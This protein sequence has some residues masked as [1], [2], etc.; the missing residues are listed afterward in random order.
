MH[1][2]I[3]SGSGNMP[4]KQLSQHALWNV[5]SM[6]LSE[7]F[8]LSVV[9]IIYSSFCSCKIMFSSCSYRFSLLL[10]E[11]NEIYF[12]DFSVNLIDENESVT[13]EDVP[14][15]GHLKMCSKSLVFDPKDMNE[16]IIKI[17]YKNCDNIYE[18]PGKINRRENNVLAIR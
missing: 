15:N 2:I 17:A 9:L 16:P 13:V 5:Y 8:P 12:E 10:L 6:R 14:R 1:M 11:P 4:K 18:W 3:A 7:G